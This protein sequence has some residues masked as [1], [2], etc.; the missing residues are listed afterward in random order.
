MGQPVRHTAWLL[1]IVLD[2]THVTMSLEPR[3]VTTAGVEPTAEHHCLQGQ[4]NAVRNSIPFLQCF[5][6]SQ[7]YLKLILLW[8]Y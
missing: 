7:C 3:S 8:L 5:N 1:A 2:T 4:T 6:M